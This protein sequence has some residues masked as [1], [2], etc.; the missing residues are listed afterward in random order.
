M[1]VIT[2]RPFVGAARLYPNQARAIMDTYRVL[3]R[4]TFGNPNE[5]RKVFPSL[6]NFKYEDQWWVIDIGGNHLRLI[7]Y[8][9]FVCNWF[10]VKHIMTHADYDKLTRLYRKGRKG[11]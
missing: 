11:R 1:N 6:D 5:M 3:K 7:A 10:Y 2:K 9:D 4:R 8:I